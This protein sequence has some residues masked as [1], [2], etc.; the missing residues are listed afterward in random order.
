MWLMTLG[1]VKCESFQR[2]FV[3]NSHPLQ[4]SHSILMAAKKT[5]E[6]HIPL[7]AA[8]IDLEKI[9]FDHVDRKTKH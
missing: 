5:K 3:K 7:F 1:K 4:G 6:W 9:K 2:A 8:N